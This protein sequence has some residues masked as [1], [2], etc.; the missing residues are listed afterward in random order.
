MRLSL[1]IYIE[2]KEKAND[3]SLEIRHKFEDLKRKKVDSFAN[4]WMNQQNKLNGQL[5]WL[6]ARYKNLLVE[7]VMSREK[8]RT[9]L[10]NSVD[11]LG[12]Q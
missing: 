1:G 8:I 7:C 4:G 2:I 9:I 12:S 10:K 3:R 6:Q 5:S 11:Y